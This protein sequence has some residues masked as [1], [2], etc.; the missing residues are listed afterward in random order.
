MK[1]KK[2]LCILACLLFVTAMQAQT[3]GRIADASGIVLTGEDFK[4]ASEA[5]EFKD[6]LQKKGRFG[7]E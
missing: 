1:T 4:K 6:L 7:F 2:L 3:G 5:S